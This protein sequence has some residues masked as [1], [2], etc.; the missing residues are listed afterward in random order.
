M[1]GGS[2]EALTDPT[3]HARDDA[4]IERWGMEAMSAWGRVCRTLRDQGVALPL[5]CPEP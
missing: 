5:G 4:A 3:A 2:V 1:P